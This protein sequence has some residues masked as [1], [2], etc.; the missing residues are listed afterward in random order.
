MSLDIDSSEVPPTVPTA[1]GRDW[2]RIAAGVAGTIAL[3]IAARV[4]FGGAL[5]AAV[6][7][8]VGSAIARQR[9]R[10]LTRLSSW[11]AA[12]VTVAVVLIG[13]AGFEAMRMDPGT[14]RQIR[15]AMDSSQAHPSPP[16]AW[17]ERIAPGAAARANARTS[18]ANP[19]F[20]TA[21]G[22][23]S[24]IVGSALVVA[25]FASFVGTVGWLATLPLAY[26]ITGS[27]IGSRAEVGRGTGRGTGTGTGTD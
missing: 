7:I 23:W 27:W 18:S 22:V 3:V 16:P 9:G 4:T 6:G 26:A 24:I 1:R 21:F 13:F 25:M 12:V 17:L 15:Q 19:T 2:K 11:I 20:A 8:G 5:V 10:R 14:F